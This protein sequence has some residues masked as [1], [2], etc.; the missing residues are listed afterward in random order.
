MLY[1]RVRQLG[2][3]SQKLHREESAMERAVL[4]G[5]V[6]PRSGQQLEVKV[7]PETAEVLQTEDGCSRT[8]QEWQASPLGWSAQDDG[9]RN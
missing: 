6:F 1:N 3:L 5:L 2:E 7:S 8:L 4:V 9:A